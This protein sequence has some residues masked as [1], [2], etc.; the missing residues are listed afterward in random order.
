GRPISIV[1]PRGDLTT[2]NWTDFGQIK[3]KLDPEG[4]ITNVEYDENQNAR[5]T[6][7]TELGTTIQIGTKYDQT[8]S[9]LIQLQDGNNNFTN[10]RLEGHGNVVEIE[11]PTGRSIVFDY[12]SNGG[13]QRIVD[14]YGFATT[15]ENY[16]PYGNA[17]QI[18]R[19]TGSG[20]VVTQ[21]TFD[22]R[23]RLLTSQDTLAPS[24]ANSYDALD[25]RVSQTVTDAS[26]Y[27]RQLT[28]NAQCLPEGQA[29]TV[30]RG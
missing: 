18:T 27:R 17:R 15:F 29:K 21:N 6:T 19:Q 8:F 4:L 23:S 9:K 26:G 5:W 10:Y 28:M 22:G 3:T 20:S 13:V 2:L 12:L 30:S 1:G 11:L 14:E 16:D 24:V 7:S 25:R